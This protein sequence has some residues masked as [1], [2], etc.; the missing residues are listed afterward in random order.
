MTSTARPRQGLLLLAGLVLLAVVAAVAVVLVRDEPRQA[1]LGRSRSTGSSQDRDA[2]TGVLVTELERALRRGAPARAEALAAPD[3]ARARRELRVLVGTVDALGLDDV[4]LRHLSRA[5]RDLDRSEERRYGDDAWVSD[6]QVSWRLPGG[7]TTLSTVDV[8]L[9][10]SWSEGRVVFETARLGGDGRV[11]MWLLGPLDRRTAGDVTVVGPRGQLPRLVRQATRAVR[12]VRRTVP[13]WEGP[14]VVEAA[15]AV[16]AFRLA[17]GLDQAAA[18]QIAAVTATSDGSTG[19]EASVHVFV[20][21]GVYGSLGPRGQQIVLSHEAA[22]VALGAVRTDAP[23]WL[24]E[25]VADYV[26]LVDSPLSVDV[27]AAQI[28]GRVRAQGAPERLPGPAEF[29]AGDDALGAWYEAAW[30]AARLV[31]EEHGEAALLELYRRADR[32]GDVGAAF[33]EV[34]G[35]T[36]RAF[37]RRWS[38]YLDELAG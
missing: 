31:A 37:E 6:V 1:E 25:G 33:R 14:L 36:E 28:L 3:D 32:D 29:E 13:T 8:P 22:H 23:L 2:A 20:N 30:L 17:S 15:P 24:S 4:E 12:T 18:E 26:A 7:G 10:T 9:V 5:D 38:S 19:A 27:L 21:P 11:P 16:G 35:T 34:L